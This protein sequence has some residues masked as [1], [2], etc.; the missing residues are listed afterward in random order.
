M[1]PKLRTVVLGAHYPEIIPSHLQAKRWRVREIWLVIQAHR[2][3]KWQRWNLIPD[4]KKIGGKKGEYSLKVLWSFRKNIYP[5]ALKICPSLKGVEVKAPLP[6]T[7]CTVK[8]ISAGL[9]QIWLLYPLTPPPHSPISKGFLLSL[10][11]EKHPITTERPVQTCQKSVNLRVWEGKPMH[12]ERCKSL[13]G[14]IS[15]GHISDALWCS[16]QSL[17]SR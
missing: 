15:M 6:S 14:H 5:S 11:A 4:V 13:H 3:S 9:P 7:M 2:R 1:Q 16:W 17:H 8:H 10:R 12:H